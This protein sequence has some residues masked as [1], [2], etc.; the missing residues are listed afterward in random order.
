MKVQW[1][2]LF[3]MN[4]ACL[5]ESILEIKEIT[6]NRRKILMNTKITP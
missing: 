5:C 4:R 1:K 2:A 6:C 3:G